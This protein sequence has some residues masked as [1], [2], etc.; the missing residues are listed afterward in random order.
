MGMYNTDEV[1]VYFLKD[2]HYSIFIGIVDKSH[3][4]AYQFS[5]NTLSLLCIFVQLVSTE[6]I[7]LKN[8]LIRNFF[9]PNNFPQN[10]WGL[11]FLTGYPNRTLADI[12]CILKLKLKQKQFTATEMYNGST[13]SVRIPHEQDSYSQILTT[14]MPYLTAVWCFRR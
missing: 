12:H 3:K 5:L 11:Q 13:I 9:K 14:E 7:N 4:T 6:D 1:R 8:K 2:R 10:C